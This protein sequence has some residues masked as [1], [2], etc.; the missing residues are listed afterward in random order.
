MIKTL[1][2][3]FKNWLND[4]PFTQSAAAAY[5]A[6]FSLP[7]L[8]II[9]MALAAIFFDQQLVEQ[10]VLGQIKKSLGADTAHSIGEIVKETQKG[11]RDI[12]GI[13]IG[14]AT[15]AFGATGLFA[16][17]Q[18]CLNKIWEVEIKKS[19]GILKV[20]QDRLISFSL[21]IVIGFLLL[22]SLSLTAALTMFGDWIA[23]AFSEEW[24]FVLY[25]VNF[26]ISISIVCSLFSLMYKILPDAIVPWRAAIMGGLLSAILFTIGEAALNMYFEMAEP[27][28]SFGAAGSV[29]LL[30]LWVSYSCMIILVGAEFSK[31]YTQEKDD[32]HAKPSPIAENKPRDLT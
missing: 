23:K 20:I 19:A 22:I 10:Q 15:L 13:V 1:K 12:W 8:L 14:I 18:R 21:I 30:M 24:L 5:Y 25:P 29:I 6:I 9:V 7:G 27:Q 31:A 2:T 3:T 4:D 26:I 16:H 11:D 32:L 17:L 28:S